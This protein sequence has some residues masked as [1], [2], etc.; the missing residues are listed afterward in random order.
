MTNILSRYGLIVLTALLAIGLPGGATATPGCVGSYAAEA[1]RPLPAK[2]VVGLDIRDRSPEV[3]RLADRF[4]AGVRDAGIAVGPEPTVLLSV[5][6][7]RLDTSSDQSNSRA[8][9]AAPGFAGLQGGV[10]MAMPAIPD[11]RLGTPASPPAPPLLIFRVEATEPHAAHSS[12]VANVQ[13]Q[14]TGTDD[15]A[16]AEDMGRVIGGVL[17]KRVDRAPF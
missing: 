8:E 3:L 2:I 10:R 16:R 1:L 11:T 14:M 9:E 17:G 6:S 15:G 5:R 13:C 7:S 12:W 4:L